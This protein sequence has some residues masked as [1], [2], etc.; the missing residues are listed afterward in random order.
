MGFEQFLSLDLVPLLQKCE[1]ELH[2]PN[3]LQTPSN[4]VVVGAI[5]VVVVVGLVFVVIVVVGVVI[6][7]VVVV[8]VVD[9][10]VVVV[11]VVVAT[12]IQL[13]K[14]YFAYESGYKDI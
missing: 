7:A 2:G 12:K 6:V 3:S 11:V 1:H 13:G 5:V 4:V 9:V 8:C 14:N 10:V